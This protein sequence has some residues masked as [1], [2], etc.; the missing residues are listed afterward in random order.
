M[1]VRDP[2]APFELYRLL[3]PAGEPELIHREAGEGASVLDLGCGTGR[4]TH[5][6]M[7][8]S[9]PVVAVDMD[10]RMLGEIRGAETVLSRVEDLHLGRTFDC[11]LLMSTLINRPDPEGRGA[12][13]RACR[14]HLAPGGVVLLERL[15]PE[16]GRDPTPTERSFAGVVI[17]VSDIRREGPLIYKTIE[18]DAGSRGSWRIRIDGRYVLGDDE[19]LADLAAARLRL[20]RWIDGTPFGL[21][22]KRWLAAEPT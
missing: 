13:L 6:L 18:Y 20:R 5:A 8:L 9:H 16:I 4:I 17:R 21:G 22:K 10:E 7:A 15:D 1:T 2:G 11:V 3:Q 12:L 19:I 14:R